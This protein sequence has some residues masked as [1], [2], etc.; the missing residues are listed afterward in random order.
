MEDAQIVHTSNISD[1]PLDWFGV[2]EAADCFIGIDSFFVNLIDQMK[3]D[4]EKKFFVRRSNI[5]FTPTLGTHW[6]Y[7]AID[8][9]IDKEHELMF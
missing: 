5:D 1:N 3:I 8:L 6:D 4:I 7:L 2:I 9:P